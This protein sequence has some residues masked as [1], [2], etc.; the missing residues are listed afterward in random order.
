MDGFNLDDLLVHREWVARVG[1]IAPGPVRQAIADR[2]VRALNGTTTPGD[3]TRQR[4]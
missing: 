3:Q 4:H 2:F 1:P